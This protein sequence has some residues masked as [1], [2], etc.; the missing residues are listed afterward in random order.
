MSRVEERAGVWA[1]LIG[2]SP[3]HLS[4]PNWDEGC[5]K[6][7]RLSDGAAWIAWGCWGRHRGA[8][9]EL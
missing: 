8:V 4:S 6:G 5:G 7:M 3:G 9:A 2:S 1:E